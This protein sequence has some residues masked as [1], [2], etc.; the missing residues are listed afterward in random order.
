LGCWVTHL[1]RR[2]A[3]RTSCGRPTGLTT[4]DGV[5]V[6]NL[7]PTLGLAVRTHPDPHRRARQ[8]L[9]HV[10]YDVGFPD[11][12][13]GVIFARDDDELIE[14]VLEAQLR[15]PSH[16]ALVCVDTALAY[17]RHFQCS[18]ARLDLRVA[19]PGVVTRSVRRLANPFSGAREAKADQ[20]QA[21]PD[22]SQHR[23]MLGVR[24]R[25]RQGGPQPRRGA[26]EDVACAPN[27]D[28]RSSPTRLRTRNSATSPSTSAQRQRFCSSSVTTPSASA[29]STRPA[30]SSICVAGCGGRNQ[31]GPNRLPDASVS[32]DGID[33]AKPVLG[34]MRISPALGV[35]G[36]GAGVLVGGYGPLDRNWRGSC[37]RIENASPMRSTLARASCAVAVM[38]LAAC[39]ETPLRPQSPTFEQLVQ[40]C[41]FELA[42]DSQGK[43]NPF[44]ATIACPG[45]GDYDLSA[46][47]HVA[48]APAAV[49]ALYLDIG[50]YLMSSVRSEHGR[51]WATFAYPDQTLLAKIQTS[52]TGWVFVTS[53]T[54]LAPDAYQY[55]HERVAVQREDRAYEE[56][57]K[58]VL[59][60][61]AS[62]RDPARAQACVTTMA[63][64]DAR[65]KQRSEQA[66]RRQRFE[67]AERDRQLMVQMQQ[68]QQEFIADEN[69]KAARQEL[70]RSLRRPAPAPVHT[71]CRKIGNTVNCQS[72]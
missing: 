52:A 50:T 14:P 41:N 70:L 17:E 72:Q 48:F 67:E 66:D 68:Q 18:R 31:P 7:V 40:Q 28:S 51:F 65:R 32:S 25:L 12:F 53:Q 22:G 64:V 71:T 34:S 21:H 56:C 39:A 15:R 11:H 27:L 10:S 13:F 44:L 33:R 29:S 35:T 61:D 58:L 62:L 20:E 23:P 47:A 6:E 55:W 19:A 60:P 24:G 36:I 57:N 1:R 38:T 69:R 9:A 26:I 3:A 43:P 16:H 4:G 63:V 45:P 59:S 2:V 46:I 5:S 8:L 49:W 42:K 54:E 30:P 37:A